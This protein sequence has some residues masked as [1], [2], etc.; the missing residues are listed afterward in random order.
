MRMDAENYN[1]NG[2]GNVDEMV[3][4]VRQ[5]RKEA[6]CEHE[7]CTFNLEE[8]QAAMKFV[9]RNAG[10]NCVILLLQEHGRD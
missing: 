9:L 10:V 1:T 7:A 8:R 3:K 5:V 2:L 6:R 4:H